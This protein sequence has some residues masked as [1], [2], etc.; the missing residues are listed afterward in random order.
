MNDALQIG[1][2]LTLKDLMTSKVKELKGHWYGLRDAMDDASQEAR[3]FDQAASAIKVGSIMT[4]AG[5][6]TGALVKN[7]IGAST[8]AGK[9]SSE[10]MSLG[11]SQSEVDKINESVRGLSGDLGIS[12]ETFLSGIYD[13]KSAVSSLDPSQLA[14]VSGEIGKL[15]VATKGDFAGLSDL[16]GTTHAQFK[17]QYAQ[18]NDTAFA[19][20]FANTMSKAVQMYKTD[21][22]KM[23]Q[24]MESLGASASVMGISL[25]EQTAV[26]GKL[27]NTMQP[28]VAGTAFRSFLTNLSGG[29]EDLGLSAVDASGNMKSVPD[30]ME[31]LKAR[32]GDTIDPAEMEVLSKAFGQEGAAAVSALINQTENLRGEIQA[33]KNE[34]EGA[35]ESLNKMKDTNLD[36]LAGQSAR[37]SEGWKSL[38]SAIGGALGEG[39]VKGFVS[40]LADIV[41]GVN[42]LLNKS[43]PLR[44]FVGFALIGVSGVLLLGGAITTLAGI[45]AMYA[46]VK[47]I[48]WLMEL[49]DGAAKTA[50]AIKT[51][52]LSGATWAYNKALT[53]ANFVQKMNLSGT[54]ALGAAQLAQAAKQGVATASKWAGAAAQWALNAA[55]AAFPAFLIIAGIGAVVAGVVWMVRNWETVKETVSAVWNTVKKSTVGA[56]NYVKE[57]VVGAFESIKSKFNSAPG[58]VKG[59]LVAAIL[60]VTGPIGAVVAAGVLLYKNWDKVKAKGADL[61]NWLQGA[62]AGGVASF[63]DFGNSVM[64]I[65]EGIGNVI[66]KVTGIFGKS[67]KSAGETFAAG[68]GM[69]KGEVSKAASQLAGSADAYLPHSDAKQGPLKNLTKSG[70]SFVTTWE[71]GIESEGRNSSTIANYMRQHTTT[72]NENSPV[73]QKV[74]G[75]KKA[76]IMA[77]SLIGQ[78]IV[79]GKNLTIE[80]MANMFAEI[81]RRELLKEGETSV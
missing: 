79:Q 31:D 56:W 74:A 6:A 81:I 59:V 22:A 70:R 28:G 63:R 36:N 23:Q 35:A 43:A 44:Q 24:A 47:K 15:A 61:W 68:M 4:G 45:T 53:A 14:G 65:F 48:G 69:S 19:T 20:L 30:L 21:G 60:M 66:G 2:V 18:L 39:P 26:L 57:K 64:G 55:T 75:A 67:G 13:I 52:I 71:E 8:E 32:F 5:V 80:E 1:A 38:K 76:G 58:W 12:Q 62:I 50:N 17:S 49:W 72:I 78:I 29:F 7:L 3:V 33:F 16:F 10:I 25:E 42:K 54:I 37:L 46:S 51:S 40:G 73:V 34:N 41:G 11:V 27:Q 77:N 9:L